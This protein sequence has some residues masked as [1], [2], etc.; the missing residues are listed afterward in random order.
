MLK[1]MPAFI[2]TALLI[3]CAAN[4]N[5]KTLIVMQ[6][7]TT[8]DIKECRADAWTTW[9]VYAEVRECSKAYEA[10]GYRVLGSY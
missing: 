10:A 7:P 2:V 6:H 8:K 9:N 3:G 4:P 1:L 5:N